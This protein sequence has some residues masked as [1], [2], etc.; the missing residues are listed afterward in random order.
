LFYPRPAGNPEAGEK[1]MPTVFNTDS[2]SPIG[3]FVVSNTTAIVSAT[4]T[5]V[6]SNTSD[7]LNVS[8]SGVLLFFEDYGSLVS[9]GTGDAVTAV[10]SLTVVVNAGS[11]LIAG[12]DAIRLSAGQAAALTLTNYGLIK[13]TVSAAI[14]G[15]GNGSSVDNYGEISSGIGAMYSSAASSSCTIYNHGTLQTSGLTALDLSG[16]VDTI[17][18]YGEIIGQANLKGGP[19][20]VFNSGTMR[21][22]TPIFGTSGDK[23]IINTGFIGTG[24][25]GND[26]I[27]LADGNDVIRNYGHID[28]SIH[29]GDG[30]DGYQAYEGATISA[31]VF[32]E[33]GADNLIGNAIDDVFDGGAGDDNLTGYGGDDTL[34]G[35]PGNDTMSGGLG[36]DVFLVE[37]AA[38]IIG[39]NTGGGTDTVVISTSYTLAAGVE[40]EFLQSTSGGGLTLTGNEFGQT[41]VGSLTADD[42]LTGGGGADVLKGQGGNDTYNL[43]ASSATIIDSAGSADLVTSTITRSLAPFAS[44]ENLTLLGSGNGIGNAL[45]N[46]ITGSAAANTLDGGANNDTLIGLGGN[47]VLIGGLGKDTMTGGLGNDTF[48]FAVAQHSPRGAGADVITDFDDFGNDRI[49]LSAVYGGTLAYIHKAAF[50]ASG[51]VRINDVAGPD[52]IVEV[53]TGG[54]LAADMQIRLVNTT[55]ASMSVGDFFL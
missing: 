50:S 40:V 44:I 13:S 30:A 36:N 18:N 11:S 3:N 22:F 54:S 1:A 53:N 7:L 9:F 26:A 24:V 2:D 19:D 51:Q 34:I 8:G 16:G 28:G 52:V 37:S 33:G 55:L 23:T 35:G 45:A 49:D 43:D 32:G 15:A 41:I 27:L 6:N 14:F 10:Q 20:A 42:I 5:N 48:R 21:A 12:G 39:E 31:A 38:D 25:P 46:T 17:N 47:D 4:Y 29:L